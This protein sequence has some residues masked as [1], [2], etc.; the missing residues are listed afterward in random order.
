MNIENLVRE[1]IKKLQP[2]SSARESHLPSEESAVLLDANENAFGSVIDDDGLMLNRYP[3]PNHRA[4]KEKLSG[5]L[6]I[7]PQRLFIGVGSDEIIDL[8]IRIFC[9]PGSDKA[10]ILEPTYGM[11]EVACNINDV[12]V[13]KVPLSKEFQIDFEAVKKSFDNKIKMIFLC[14]P[15]NPTSNL[16]DATS[17][18]KL[19]KEFSVIVVVD[20]AYYDFA[21]EKTDLTEA[22]E[23][24]NIILLRTF[25]KAWGLAGIRCGYCIAD[26]EI[27]K[28]FYKIKLPYNLNK[29]T[30][31]K[32]IEALNKTEK[33]EKLKSKII[34]Q[35]KFLSDELNKINGVK[36]IYPSDANFLLFEVENPKEV[37][38][39]L[40]KKGIIVRD[41]SSQVKGCLRVTV[42]TEEE[43]QKFINELKKLL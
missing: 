24:T 38:T 28:Y 31:S 10:M 17:I 21:E 32:I 8:V 16:I 37:Y 20:Q 29:L 23:T 27:I 39:N 36:K 15:N 9:N 6:G 26:K 22:G 19:A 34:L 4:L 41:R 14:S 2:Y 7:S 18:I 13:V 5:Y 3:D 1:N 35:R 12:N 30:S 40:A 33:K 25:S 42:G 11:Y 43:N